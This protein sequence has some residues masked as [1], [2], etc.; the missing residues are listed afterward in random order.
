MEPFENI[1]K[2]LFTSLIYAHLLGKFQLILTKFADVKL[3]KVPKGVKKVIEIS[4]V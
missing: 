2:K 1:L 4:T 3:Q